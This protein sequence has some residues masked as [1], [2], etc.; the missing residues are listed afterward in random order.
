MENFEFFDSLDSIYIGKM[1]LSTLLY[2]VVIFIICLVLIR[3][4][5]HFVNR[6]LGKSKIENGLK[7]FI[8]SALKVGLWVLVV[9]IVADCLG[10]PSASLIAVL[11]V[12]GLALSL[13]LQSILSNLFSGITV[14]ATKPFTSGDYVE[15]GGVSGTVKSVG[16]FY[17]LLGT[18]DNKLIYIPNSDVT[19]SKITNF[20]R[21][22]LRRLDMTFEVSY[23][24][25]TESVKSA[26]A[27]VIAAESRILP[28]PPPQIV[29]N[30]FKESSVEYVIR[31]WV[32]S[33]DYWDIYYR[34]NEQVRESFSR[35]S[36]SIAYPNV[37]IRV[38]K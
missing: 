6:L 38:V 2:A 19:A 17:T 16:L 37:N 7:S 26:L 14:L 11:S 27:E 21:E 31:A 1:S 30:S 8:R 33:N 12:A 24:N 36:I 23:V 5:M 29:L 25:S 20:T 13:A 32:N 28:D 3:I 34:M 4:I 10:I 18:I 22:P 35:N 15:L 9:V